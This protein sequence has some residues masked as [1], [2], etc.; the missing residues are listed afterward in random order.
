MFLPHLAG[1][2]LGTSFRHVQVVIL[3]HNKI[4][5]EKNDMLCFGVSVWSSY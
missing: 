4:E 1:D 2:V 5:K 3:A